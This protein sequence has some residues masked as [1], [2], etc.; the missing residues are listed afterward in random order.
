MSECLQGATGGGLATP[1]LFADV[2]RQAVCEDLRAATIPAKPS[3]PVEMNRMRTKCLLVSQKVLD[4][5]RSG[6]DFD[7][8]IRRVHLCTGCV[9][10]DTW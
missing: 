9:D 7:S 3:G 6:I 4:E 2:Q 8:L 5:T 10:A 1:W